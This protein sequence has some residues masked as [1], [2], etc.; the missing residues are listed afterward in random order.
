M[1]TRST[2]NQTVCPVE[3]SL[4]MMSGKWKV[5]IL[6]KLHQGSILRFGELRKAL[7]GITEK[8]LAQQLRELE[9]DGL[10]TRKMYPEVPPRVEYFMSPFGQTLRPILELIAQWSVENQ[11]RILKIF[12]SRANAQS[13]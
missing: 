5:R 11:K 4:E 2:H 6:W 12:E 1:K 13:S 9:R 10:V 3:T 8:M 7:P